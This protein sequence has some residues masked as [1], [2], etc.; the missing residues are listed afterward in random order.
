MEHG[1]SCGHV[2]DLFVRS[3]SRRQRIGSVLMS[4]LINEC[5]RRNLGAINVEVARSSAPA[6][7]LYRGLGFEELQDGRIFLQNR[8]DTAL[9]GSYGAP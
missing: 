3:A 8:L 1:A 7:A 2:D 6:F 9:V 4:E 5:R